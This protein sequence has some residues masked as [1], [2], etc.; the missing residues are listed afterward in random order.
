[1]RVTV[2]LR[3]EEHQ[4]LTALAYQNDV[5]ISWIVRKAIR[6]YLGRHAIGQSELNFS[7]SEKDIEQ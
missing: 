4:N 2:T 6:E 5:S 3:E 1:M 7:V